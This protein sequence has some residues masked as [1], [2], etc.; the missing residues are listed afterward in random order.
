MCWIEFET[1][2]KLQQ[3]L[4]AHFGLAKFTCKGCTKVTKT[5]K[6]LQTHYNCYHATEPQWVVCDTCDRAHRI[7][8]TKWKDDW[9][10]HKKRCVRKPL[11]D[12]F[13]D[14]NYARHL[15]ELSVVH[16]EDCPQAEVQPDCDRLPEQPYKKPM[17]FSQISGKHVS[18]KV[19]HFKQ[20]QRYI[21]FPLL[22]HGPCCMDFQMYICIECQSNSG[23][24]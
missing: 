20:V 17:T 2:V 21:I 8:G 3:H 14:H 18:G 9:R 19:S 5:L 15:N 13:L 16:E 22:Q 7:D 1:P 10:T 11:A 4:K 23:G 24:L 6:C 12:F